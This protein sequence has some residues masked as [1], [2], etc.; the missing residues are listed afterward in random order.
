M[1]PPSTLSLQVPY[2][3]TEQQFLLL[4]VQAAVKMFRSIDVSSYDRM[5]A[6]S[7]GEATVPESLASSGIHAEQN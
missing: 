2:A 4:A 1:P 6:G 3:E 5:P 7:T